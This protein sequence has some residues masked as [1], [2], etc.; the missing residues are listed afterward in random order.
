M[1]GAMM[2]WRLAAGRGSRGSSRQ[3][4]QRFRFAQELG[5]A[6]RRRH[7]RVGKADEA[8]S[9]ELLPKAPRIRGRFR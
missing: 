1:Q 2:R 6:D 7:Q 5:P 9:A 4:S 8:G 3:D